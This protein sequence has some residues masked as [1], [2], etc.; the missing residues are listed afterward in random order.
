M[1][2]ALRI[3]TYTPNPSEQAVAPYSMALILPPVGAAS[4]L[5]ST[6]VGRY[7]G[8]MRAPCRLQSAIER[9]QFRAGGNRQENGPDMLRVCGIAQDVARG[10]AFLHSKNIVHGGALPL[11]LVFAASAGALPAHT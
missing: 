1:N 5:H 2:C 4:S 6:L 10:M 3:T 11:P 8:I 7:H 9:G